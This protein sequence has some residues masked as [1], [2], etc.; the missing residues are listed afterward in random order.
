MITHSVH[1]YYSKHEIS[2]VEH[3]EMTNYHNCG[4]V[5][6]AQKQGHLSI[7]SKKGWYIESH[8]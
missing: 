5:M 7:P 3:F 4:K 1:I 8:S 2:D 6:T